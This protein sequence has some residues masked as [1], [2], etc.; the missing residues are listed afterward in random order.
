MTL[1]WPSR[2]WWSG[3]CAPLQPHILSLSPLLFCS[4]IQTFSQFF[5]ILHLF[6]T[7]GYSLSE[8]IHTSSSGQLSSS[9][10][11][12][13][14]VTS[15]GRLYLSFQ[16]NI[17]ASSYILSLMPPMF[18][19]STYVSLQALHSRC[20]LHWTENSIQTKNPQILHFL[21]RAWH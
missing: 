18:L 6:L 17:C 2:S 4:L 9:S 12:S 8:P 5:K 15:S 11:L 13:Y 20:L 21:H 7:S 10:G 19:Y 16:T 1:S 14:N 3:S